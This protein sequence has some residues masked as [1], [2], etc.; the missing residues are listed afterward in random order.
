MQF[1]E[2]LQDLNARMSAS[3]TTGF[4]SEENKKRW[5]NKA[6][7]RACNFARW[8]FLKK[9]STINT[10]KDKEA[11]YLPFDYKAMIFL[12]VNGETYHPTDPEDYESGN[13]VWE[14]VFTIIGDQFLIKPTI[15]E[16]G[17]TIDI[18]HIRR[19]VP[20]VDET[21]EA[22]TPEEMDEPIVKFALAVCLKKEPG[23]AND[24]REEILEANAMLQGV[25]DREDEEQTG[26]F[27]GQAIS[28]RHI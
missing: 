23:R 15:D 2:F 14:K 20:L 9:H 4:W 10:E 24:A 5:I 21:D 11:Y 7:I 25:K 18:Y 16:D 1:Q 3:K 6:I 26:I 17:K 12:K 28:S 27:K 22:I 13:H 8:K 19:P